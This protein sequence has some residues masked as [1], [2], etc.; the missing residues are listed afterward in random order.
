MKTAGIGCFR[1]EKGENVKSQYID[2]DRFE[3]LLAAMTVPDNA[4]ALRVSLETGMRIGDVLRLRAENV[5]EDGT[6]NAIAQKTGKPIMARLSASTARLIT[7]RG[8]AGW[9]FPS[10]LD[11]TKHRARQTVWRALKKAAR[12][13]GV[14]E[15]TTPHSARKIYAVEEFR[16]RGLASVQERLG[17]DRIDTSMIYAFADKLAPRDFARSADPGA[18]TFRAFMA[19]F[20]KALGGEDVVDTAFRSALNCLPR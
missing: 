3:F 5:S 20:V 16:A 10:P 11:A 13:C 18:A 9:V 12:L 4:L 7:A 6:I 17:H 1:C 19:A 14:R 2:K 15:N 8:A